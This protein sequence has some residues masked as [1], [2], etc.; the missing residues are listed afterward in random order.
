M[1]YFNGN[2][3]EDLLA[4]FLLDLNCRK[5]LTQYTYPNEEF[6]EQ[7][8]IDEHIVKC[9]D[10]LELFLF[11]VLASAGIEREERDEIVPNKL[12]NLFPIL[13]PYIEQ[14]IKE[15]KVEYFTL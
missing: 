4:R 9:Q 8:A 13:E 11:Q 7:G 14:Y 6:F 1:D 10:L 3:N 15:V 2:T 5:T 12:R